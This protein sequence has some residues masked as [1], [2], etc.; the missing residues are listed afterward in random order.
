MFGVIRIVAILVT[1]LILTGRAYAGESVSCAEKTVTFGCDA[2]FNS[3][4]LWKGI[5]INDKP[6][7]QPTLWVSALDLTLSVFGN[8]I[9]ENEASRGKFNEFDFILGYSRQFMNFTVEPSF[10]FYTF[11]N[12][13]ESPDTGMGILR[14]SY[15]AGPVNIFISHAADL[16]N[17][18]PAG[19]SEAGCCA[20]YAINDAVSASAMVYLGAGSSKFNE[21]YIGLAKDAVNLAGINFSVTYNAAKYF[22]IQPHVEIISVMD[23]DLRNQI[24]DPELN[25]SSADVSNIGI[26]VSFEF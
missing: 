12:Q 21:T 8:F 14:V 3:K 2:D 1:V 19:F 24:S 9:Q 11:P 26:N 18:A 6:V 13:D 23:G 5:V 10:E 20:D 7:I 16:V 4:Y 22:S 25:D 15:P 17:Y